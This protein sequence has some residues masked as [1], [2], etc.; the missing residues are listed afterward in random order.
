MQP[1][2]LISCAVPESPRYKEAVESAGGIPTEVYCSSVSESLKYDGVIITGGG[3]VHPELYAQGDLGVSLALDRK[4]DE[5]ECAMIHAYMRGKKPILAICR[6]AQLLNAALGGT[7]T[8]DI[9]EPQR[10]IH[11]KEK[12]SAYHAV[13]AERGSFLY[14]L[15]GM[16]SVVNSI[17]HQALRR[18]GKG[19]VPCQWS[20]DGIVEGFYAESGPVWGVQWHPERLC[21]AAYRPEKAV[22]GLILFRWW[23]RQILQD[24]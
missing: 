5:A 22:D 12:G 11:R 13:K 15:Y 21:N 17:H 8:Q 9:S 18:L 4:R 24:N 1:R 19:L 10:S 16:N 2:I 20:E 23:I 14:G 6:G 7:L 3:D